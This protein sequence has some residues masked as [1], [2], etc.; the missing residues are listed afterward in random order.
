MIYF[1]RNPQLY[2]EGGNFRRPSCDR[3]PLQRLCTITAI[4]ASSCACLAVQIPTHGRGI[5]LRDLFT[6]VGDIRPTSKIP[7]RRVANMSLALTKMCRMKI[8]E[9][10]VARNRSPRFTR[11]MR[12][13]RVDL[14]LP[15]GHEK[16]SPP[17]QR[18]AVPSA[19]PSIIATSPPA[20][21]VLLVVH[22]HVPET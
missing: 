4:Y 15:K 20:V 18:P 11:G 8:H 5:D 2:R 19:K 13:R 3:S 7:E 14:L 10:A 12:I 9:E 21:Q 16:R 22:I 17:R 1:S 6:T